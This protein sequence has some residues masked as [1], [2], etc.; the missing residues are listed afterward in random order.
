MC[1]RVDVLTPHRLTVELAGPWAI[2][3]RSPSGCAASA[4]TCRAQIPAGVVVTRPADT[5]DDSVIGR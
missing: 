5:S 4:L 3:Y 2:A 1:Y